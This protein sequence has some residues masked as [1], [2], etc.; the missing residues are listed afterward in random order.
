[1]SYVSHSCPFI[2]KN[3]EQHDARRFK[4]NDR[5][6][7]RRLIFNV[8]KIVLKFLPR[9]IERRAIWVTD[10]SPTGQPRFHQMALGVI[11]DALF[12]LLDELRAFRARPDQT[13]LAAQYVEKLRDLIDAKLADDPP[14]SR[15][16]RVVHAR[17]DRALGFGVGPHRAE[18]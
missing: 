15:R 16:P 12:E 2:V 18:L 3:P 13:H 4:Q 14:D 11:R 8:I 1:M 5:V 10:L 9:V 7:K 17:P 6:E